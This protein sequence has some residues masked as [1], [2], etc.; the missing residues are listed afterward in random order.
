VIIDRR[1]YHSTAAST[2]T[3]LIKTANMANAPASHLLV[4]S[5]RDVVA[6]ARQCA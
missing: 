5:Q 4:R 6:T 1:P 2:I 3:A